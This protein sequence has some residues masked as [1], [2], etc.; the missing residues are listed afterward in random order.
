MRSGLIDE[1]GWC[2]TEHMLPDAMTKRM[3]DRLITTYLQTGRWKPEG[4]ELL[5]RENVP[6]P[7]GS[8][9]AK[10]SAAVASASSSS[11]S[12]NSVSPNSSATAASESAAPSTFW[13]CRP[14]CSNCV[15]AVAEELY[16]AS[17]FPLDG[18]EG[19]K[20]SVF[21]TAEETMGSTT[22]GPSLAQV[23]LARTYLALLTRP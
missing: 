9:R 8:T 1:Y 18:A 23:A 10:A 19:E 20:N 6:V 17:E 7:L 2:P 12:S 21:F 3:Q 16:L 15:H 4:Y 11:S 13:T 5:L 22:A 14:G